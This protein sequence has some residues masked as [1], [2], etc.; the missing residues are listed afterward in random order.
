MQ[1]TNVPR[2]WKLFWTRRAF[3]WQ[4][5]ASSTGVCAQSDSCAAMSSLQICEE[6]IALKAGVQLGKKRLFGVS[7]QYDML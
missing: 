6:P 4:N 3:N 7:E 2:K 1:M 5:A